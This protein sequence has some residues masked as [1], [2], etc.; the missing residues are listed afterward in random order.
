MVRDIAFTM[1]FGLPLIMY[2][3]L[4][5]LFFLL[6]TAFV[7]YM[8]FHGKTLIPFKWHPRLAAVTITLAILHGLMGLSV[9]LRF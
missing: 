8:N 1:V 4:A 2:G 5:T 7:G 6:F 9:L 3:G